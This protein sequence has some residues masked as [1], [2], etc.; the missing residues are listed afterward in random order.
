MASVRREGGPPSA[1]TLKRVVIEEATKAMDRSVKLV[2]SEWRRQLVPN[3]DGYRTG[4]YSRSI[5]STV[6]TNDTRVIGEV[7]TKLYYAPYLEYGTGIYGPRHEL[8]RS[9]RPGGVLRFPQPGN[10]GFTLAGRRR[11]G[12][13][14]AMAQYVYA[15]FI[16]GIKPRLYAHKA[17][18]QA[19]TAVRAEFEAAGGRIAKRLE[20]W[21]V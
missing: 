19:R 21:K 2:E 7:G 12:R 16:R 8:I 17:A 14:G 6:T 3:E 11:S 4:T 13:A 20:G 5:T 9:T 10:P 15:R 18:D 1:E